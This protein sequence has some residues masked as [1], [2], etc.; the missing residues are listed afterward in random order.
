MLK[1]QTKSPDGSVAYEHFAVA[2]F[3]ITQGAVTLGERGRAGYYTGC[4][5]CKVLVNVIK[6]INVITK[7]DNPIGSATY[8]SLDELHRRRGLGQG[9]DPA[10]RGQGQQHRLQ[11]LPGGGPAALDLGEDNLDLALLVLRQRGG[12]GAAVVDGYLEGHGGDAQGRQVHDILKRQARRALLEDRGQLTQVAA[13]DDTDAVGVG[14]EDAEMVEEV[15][16]LADVGGQEV[17]E[18]ARQMRP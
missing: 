10:H 4:N 11:P 8:F 13:A 2:S 3:E 12:H 9:G 1:V 15:L 5:L 14:L 16:H 6:C 17:M 7:D 18:Q